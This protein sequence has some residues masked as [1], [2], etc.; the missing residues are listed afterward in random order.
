MSAEGV[1][2]MWAVG[3]VLAWSGVCW[4][5]GAIWEAKRGRR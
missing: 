3:I 1:M 5:A 2:A 4:S